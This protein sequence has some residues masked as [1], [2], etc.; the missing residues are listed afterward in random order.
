MWTTS[1]CHKL[2][3]F[4]E[5]S[6]HH[7]FHYTGLCT[8][9]SCCRVWKPPISLLHEKFNAVGR[10]QQGTR[11]GKLHWVTHTLNHFEMREI[12]WK[13]DLDSAFNSCNDAGVVHPLPLRFSGFKPLVCNLFRSTDAIPSTL[14]CDNFRRFANMNR[15]SP[16]R[17]KYLA[18]T[19]TTLMT[20]MSVASSIRTLYFSSP[21]S[22]C[23]SDSKCG[24]RTFL[25]TFIHFAQWVLVFDMTTL[26]WN[27]RMQDSYK[28]SMEF[29]VQLL[30]TSRASVPSAYCTG[31]SS[32]SGVRSLGCWPAL[33]GVHVKC[34]VDGACF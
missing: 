9:L 21:T 2:V 32:T 15:T 33:L 19:P 34:F 13:L 22:S 6:C 27:I 8:Q 24:P 10:A 1:G 29:I 20:L 16:E 30:E 18:R 23:N 31:D 7:S 3:V 14:H 11:N 28:W 5:E 17:E 4:W 26:S 12:L 25:I